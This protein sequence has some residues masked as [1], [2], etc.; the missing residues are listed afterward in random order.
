MGQRETS[1][2]Q[3]PELCKFMFRGLNIGFED[4][5]ALPGDGMVEDYTALDK[6]ELLNHLVV[7]FL[8]DDDVGFQEL[9][10]PVR[11]EARVISFGDTY[12]FHQCPPGD[13]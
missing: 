6:K 9:R 3:L 2:Q 1:G 10:F 11:D 7:E 12:L 4:S 5:T 13:K 8:G